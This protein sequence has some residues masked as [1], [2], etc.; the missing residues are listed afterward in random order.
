[1]HSDLQTPPGKGPFH[2]WNNPADLEK[3]DREPVHI[4]GTIMPHGVLLILT[5]DEGRIA[6]I[7]ANVEFW[8]KDKPDDLLNQRLAA[9]FPDESKQK[10]ENGL[11]EISQAS[12]PRYFG[13]FKTLKSNREFD[14]FAHRSGDV[15]IV[16]FD[17]L[18]EGAKAGYRHRTP[19][20]G[21]RG[22]RRHAG[23]P[24]LAGRHGD[25]RAG[26]QT[27]DR[28]GFGYRR[29]HAWRMAPAMPW[30][31]SPECRISRAFLDKRFPRSDIPDPARRQMLLMPVQ[32]A[33]EHDY[34]PVP[35]IM[36]GGRP[37][38]SGIDL[39]YSVLRSMSRMCSQYYLNMGAGGRLLL[40][41]TRPGRIV[42]VF[43]LPQRQAKAGA[44]L[45]PAR[46]SAFRR[47]GGAATGGK[48]EG[49]V[50]PPM[51]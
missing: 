13:C 41:L 1:M 22:H 20:A 34:R 30:P 23:R 26:T 37:D 4:S 12:P 17:S 49:R 45:R 2:E 24:N 21:E 14:V 16:E 51:S 7:S 36:A 15:L 27:P 48:T 8:F 50:Y 42:G 9:I 19:R 3:C 39:T 31:R 28:N 6:G 29:A 40:V 18:P 33:P 10:L 25:R 44:L 5:P 46:L 43:Q 11:A 35:V 32:Y 38:A 47:N